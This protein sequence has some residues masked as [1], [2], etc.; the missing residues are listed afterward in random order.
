MDS[1]GVIPHVDH[2]V[3]GQEFHQMLCHA[4]SA[5]TR[6]PA[7]V[8]Y[9]EGLVQVQVANIGPYVARAGKPHLGIHIRAIH[10]DLPATPVDDVYHL[11][12][13]AL[14]YP[15]G[16]GVGYHESTQRIP[17]LLSLP[18]EILYVYIALGIAIYRYY[19][20]ASHNGARGVSAMRR[21][22][23]KHRGPLL[24]PVG[25]MVGPYHQEPCVLARRPRVRLQ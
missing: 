4:D 21:G 10:V 25:Y 14:E 7:P 12:Y 17:V 20:G 18:T 11:P 15:V 9:G 22:G 23:N 1:L 19:V 24:L 13:P 16:G 6:P 5:H 3:L 2:A 8:R